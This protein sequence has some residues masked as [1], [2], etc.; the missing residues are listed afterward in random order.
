MKEIAKIIYECYI[1]LNMEKHYQAPE[2]I[3]TLSHKLLESLNNE[4]K[5]LFYKYDLLFVD[6]MY[7][8]ELRLLE[9]VLEIIYDDDIV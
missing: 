4:Q 2:E 3:D 9:F 6:H 5:E 8:R 7:E 1:K